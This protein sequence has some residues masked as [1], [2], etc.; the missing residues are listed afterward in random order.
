[1][2]RPK[3]IQE[4][5]QGKQKFDTK[6]LASVASSRLNDMGGKRLKA[7]K[8][9]YCKKYHYGH[10]TKGTKLNKNQTNNIPPFAYEPGVH[11]VKNIWVTSN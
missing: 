8:C 1:M 9:D 4:Q 5:C 3:E 2:S 10:D 6:A 11:K 7:Y